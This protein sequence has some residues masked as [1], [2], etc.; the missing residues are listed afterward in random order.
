MTKPSRKKASP[1]LSQI[2]ALKKSSGPITGTSWTIWMKQ[3][4][5]DTYMEV[6]EVVK[7]YCDQGHTYSVFRSVRA[8]HRYLIGKDP[9]RK[10]EPIIEVSLDAF[11][12]FVERVRN[13]EE[14]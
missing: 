14:K 12:R 5:P 13:G 9:E 3:R 7:D 8:L 11:K 10:V 2:K 1:L 4:H 6:M